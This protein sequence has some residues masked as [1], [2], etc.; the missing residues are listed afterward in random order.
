MFALVQSVALR[1]EDVAVE[2][3]TVACL[4]D[5]FLDLGTKAVQG[6][7]FVRIV[8]LKDLTDGFQG[9]KIL[10]FRVILV[11]QG[12]GRSWISIGSCKINSDAQIN[13]AAPKDILEKIDR[14]LF[15]K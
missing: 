13:I 7:V 5:L 12:V 10:I 6:H 2:G 14:S 9:L 15:A 4:I 11:V 1:I 3:K 8:V